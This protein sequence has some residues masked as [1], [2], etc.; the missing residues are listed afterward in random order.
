MKEKN[1]KAGISLEMANSNW[2]LG[3]SF[4]IV[5]SSIILIPFDLSSYKKQAVTLNEAEWS[6]Q[7]RIILTM[8]TRSILT[9]FSGRSTNEIACISQKKMFSCKFSTRCC[10][11]IASWVFSFVSLLPWA[12][13]NAM[14]QKTQGTITCPQG[15]YA[16]ISKM[17]ASEV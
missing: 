15:L 13:Y 5:V 14:Y 4:T 2:L 6:N 16:S 7:S 1:P 17:A 10:F 11:R 9:F 3:H 8:M 12:D